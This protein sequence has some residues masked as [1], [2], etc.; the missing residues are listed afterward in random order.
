MNIVF[1][2]GDCGL[3]Q[4]SIRFLVSADRKKQLLFAP[5]NGEAYKKIYG[6]IQSPLTT[7]VFHNTGRTF[8]KSNAFLEICRLIGGKFTFFYFFKIVPRFIRDFVYDAIAARRKMISCTLLS[9]DERF[10]K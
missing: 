9:K 10:L 5:L 2:D 6:E 7:V 3:C 4:R 8:E 1:Y